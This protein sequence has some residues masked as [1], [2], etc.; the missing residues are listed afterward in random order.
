MDHFWSEEQYHLLKGGLC[1]DVFLWAIA[2]A[3]FVIVE[4]TTVQLVSVWFAAGALITLICTYFFELSVLQQL[5]IFIV[6]SS[7]LLAASLPYL[8]SRRN[9][10][11]IAT[12]SELDIGKNASVIEDIDPAKGSGRV[13]L[14]GVDWSAV[15]L[16]SDEIIPAGSIVKVEEVQGSKL[17]VSLKNN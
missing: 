5:G 9:I 11:H 1:M 6:A 14:N 17:I 2:V 10:E 8:R 3:A 7:I 13:T 4:I 15:P 16:A 12:N